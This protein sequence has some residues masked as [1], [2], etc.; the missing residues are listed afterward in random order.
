[1]SKET[2][3]S[4]QS[5]LVFNLMILVF[6]AIFC[7]TSNAFAATAQLS[8]DQV[9][10]SRVTGYY[11]YCG[12]S[13]IDYSAD[14]EVTIN[15]VSQTTCSISGLQEGQIYAFAAKSF[16]AD[17]NTSSPTNVIYHS[18][19]ESSD[20][21]TDSENI[22]LVVDN[23]DNSFST[24]GKW[25][26]SSSTSGYYGSDYAVAPEGSGD[27]VASW[28]FDIPSSGQ[29]EVS[30]HWTAH[31]N[32]APD[33][34]YIILNNG[35][36]VG[37]VTVD[38]TSNGSQFNSL[39][40]FN[41]Q[42]GSLV[43][44]LSNDVSGYLI[45]DAVK[46]AGLEST[47]T[48]QDTDG[49]G[50]TDEE[51]ENIYLSDPHNPDTDGDGIHD[52][53]EVAYWGSAWS[54]DSDGD[55]TIN[56][57]DAD[58]DGDSISDGQELETNTDPA[59]P[60]DISADTEIGI[61]DNTSSKF[62]TVGTWYSS[63]ST[64]GYY[65][66]DYLYAADGDGSS[67]AIWT[68]EIANPGTYTIFARWTA[69][70]NRA[71]DAPYSIINNDQIV[72]EIQVDQTQDGGEFN[73]LGTF[74]LRSGKVEICL[75]NDASEYVIADAVKLTISEETTNNTE[76]ETENQNEESDSTEESNNDVE[77]IVDNKSES[78]STIGDWK[79]SNSTPGYYESDYQVA[80][81]G[82]GDRSASW[83]FDVSSAGQFII[84]AHWTSHPNRAPDAT[85]I[86]TNNGS[87]LGQTTMDQTR[88]GSTFNSLGAFELQPGTVEVELTNDASGY[89]I[90]DAMKLTPL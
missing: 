74:D 69:F 23:K 3:Q 22:S 78:F 39:G 86:I 13:D 63:T 38:Q 72:G 21:N 12:E 9:S 49:D 61:I 17:G 30:A 5:N 24:D 18:V 47:G 27:M 67:K 26:S 37:K 80:P 66:S 84:S 68:F 43:V 55:G 58:S 73:S 75:S 54:E 6:S 52:G 57:L 41:L 7:F 90:A 28:A 33:A 76:D 70:P 64:P 16:D 19:P 25:K 87:Y 14:L 59:D 36:S 53:D 56:L 50:L 32:R 88:D 51:E 35:N 89:V 40:S 82:Y 10:D 81:E 11:I 31:P 65:D 46:L 1:M 77:S 34:E 29:Y 60:N 8:W 48:A 44:R 4:N 2:S 20:S 83:T 42:S 71:T 62:S 79:S 15:D 85:Y 45:A